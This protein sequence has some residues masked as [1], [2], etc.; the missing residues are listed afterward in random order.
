MDKNNNNPPIPSDFFLYKNS[1]GEVKVEIY[2]FNETVWLPQDKI[3]QLFGVDRSIVTEHLK[4]VYKSGEL[5]KGVTCAIFAQVQIEG[6]G[7]SQ[8]RLSFTISTLSYP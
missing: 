4:N 6:T 1:N 2:I 3:A 7:R 5:S 8:D